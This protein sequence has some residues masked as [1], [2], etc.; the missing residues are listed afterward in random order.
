MSK[1]IGTPIKAMP[2]PLTF[3]VDEVF[4][5]ICDAR[6]IRNPD[7]LSDGRYRTLRGMAE[8][9]TARLNELFAHVAVEA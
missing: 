6:G 2:A 8:Q 4:I 3:T 7:Y 5:W 9:A 1:R